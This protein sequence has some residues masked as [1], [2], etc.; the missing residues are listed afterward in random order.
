MLP[1][2]VDP[3]DRTVVGGGVDEAGSGP[4][5]SNRPGTNTSTSALVPRGLL[6]HLP[7]RARAA[8]ALGLR[9]PRRAAISV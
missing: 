9:R 4:F 6:S 3:G 8:A 2:I 5:A 7:R 1:K